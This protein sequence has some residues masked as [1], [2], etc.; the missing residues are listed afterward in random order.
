MEKTLVEIK[1]QKL[2]P[3][4][5]KPVCSSTYW[6]LTLA[7]EGRPARKLHSQSGSGDMWGYSS[8][9]E[10]PLKMQNVPALTPPPPVKRIRLLVM[11]KTLKCYHLSQQAVLTFEGSAIWLNIRQLYMFLKNCRIRFSHRTGWFISSVPDWP[12]CI[13]PLFRQKLD[14]S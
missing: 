7:D 5:I 8:L 1:C 14:L 4:K 2:I 11:L 13:C 9:A 6:R 12:C 3:K 10:H